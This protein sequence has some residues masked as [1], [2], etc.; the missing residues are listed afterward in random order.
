M[1]VGEI[2][3]KLKNVPDDA[4]FRIESI[5]DNMGEIKSSP[6][7]EICYDEKSNVVDVRPLTISSTY[8]FV[9]AIS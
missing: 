9:R 1:K 2:K 5:C 7:I 8:H 4:E 3:E 6:C